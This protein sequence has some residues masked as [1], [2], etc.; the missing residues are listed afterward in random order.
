MGFRVLVIGG[1]GNF[2]GRIA[3]RLARDAAIEVIVAGRDPV[4]AEAF[5]RSIEASGGTATLSCALDIADSGWVNALD[6]LRPALVIHAAGPFQAQGYA[7]AEAAIACG[8]HY[9]DLADSREFVTGFSA[10]LDAAARARGVLAVTGASTLPAVSAAV[11]DALADGFS[12]IDA[13]ECGISPGNHSA[14]GTATIAAILSYLGR[15]FPQWR[16]GRWQRAYGWQQL[17]RRRYPAPMGPRWL[18]ACDVSDLALFPERYGTARVTFKAG[19][20]LAPLHIGLWLVSWFA[21]AGLLSGLASHAQAMARMFAMFRRFGSDAGGMHLRVKGMDVAQRPL[22]RTWTI[23][24]ESGDGP[25][26]P[27]TPAV[28]LAKKLA[29]GDLPAT[30]ARV[31]LDLF[32]LDEFMAGVAGYAMNVR[33]ETARE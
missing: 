5:S 13:I 10:Q 28:L 2:G 16:E 7:V 9:V 33:E 26:I 27:C 11:I 23:V 6:S 3:A 14:P 32:T 29:R 12:R 4:Q 30:G 22:S 19:I 17:E 15:P 21:R 31:C 18:S 20:E 8:F 24:A 25:E 1:Y